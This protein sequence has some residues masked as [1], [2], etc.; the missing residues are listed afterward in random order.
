MTEEKSITATNGLTV[1]GT[2][3]AC[4]KTAA[5]A[6]VGYLLGKNQSIR[7]VKPLLC[8]PRERAEAE[9]SFLSSVSG[10]PRGYAFNYV[11]P[12]ARLSRSAWQSILAVAMQGLELNLIEA[13]GAISSPIFVED[14]DGGIIVFDTLDFAKRLSYPVLIVAAHRFDAPERLLSACAMAEARGLNIAGLLTVET[15][16]GEGRLLEAKYSRQDVELLFQSRC[17]A[18]YLGCI[19]HSPSI[20]VHRVNQGNLVKMTESGLDIL[21]LYKSLAEQGLSLTV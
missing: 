12:P 8:G 19:K 14:T 6:V 9:V 13:Y 5:T 21:S 18:P 3:F 4:G 11:E 7:V 16:A 20:N 10:A 15:A 2:D 17:R 1:L